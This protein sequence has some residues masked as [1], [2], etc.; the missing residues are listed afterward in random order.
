MDLSFFDAVTA[1]L[2]HHQMW[3][4]PVIAFVS[5]VESLVAV[6]IIVPGVAMLF[7]LGV[8]A[9]TG[10][11]PV[12]AILAWAFAGAVT[13]DGVSYWLGYRYHAGLKKM[14]PFNQHPEWLSHGEKFFYKYGTFSV[15]IG[16]FVGAARPFIPVVA[17]MMNMPP[18]TFYTVNIL[19]AL[20]WAPVYLLPGYFTGAAMTMKD[21]LP[22][23]LWI[24]S[25][26]LC[27][28]ALLLPAIWFGLQRRIRVTLILPVALLGTGFLVLTALE[29]SGQLQ[30]FNQQ[31]SFWLEALRLSW[32]VD[33]M[34]WLTW[35][36]S[37]PVAL[38]LTAVCMLIWYFR[39]RSAQI[40]L[41]LW[42]IPLMEASLWI[43]KWSVN[44]AR[45]EIL[46]S[47]DPFSFP[48]GHT[49][50]ATFFLLL[51][52]GECPERLDRKW[53]WGIYSV[54]LLLVGLVA[55]SR[56]ILN[57]HWLGDVLAG[58]CLG[59]FWLLIASV[60]RKRLRH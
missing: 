46:Q 28:V 11:M 2:E 42:I 36:G 31:T 30:S 38:L 51:L 19:S 37:L 5:C 47:L 32:L 9:G 48:S 24:L 34:S 55:L 21:Q 41:L 40:H 8:I 45:P 60:F 23:Q 20:V 44:S 27:A 26:S 17:G 29:L 43:T 10:I 52:A 50:Q 35:L 1:W 39:Q 59:L 49:T 56:L 18:V 54:S 53:Q 3:L 58:F 22:Q 4:G 14:W 15:V 13:G 7:A 12:W 6:G 16:R 57:A 25:G 33:I